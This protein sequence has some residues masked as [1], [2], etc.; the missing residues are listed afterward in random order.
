VSSFGEYATL[1]AVMVAMGIALRQ[2]RAD[3]RITKS[4]VTKTLVNVAWY[5]LFS[6]VG[7]AI[8]FALLLTAHGPHAE[9]F[10]IG[11]F[12]VWILIGIVWMTRT[13]PRLREPPAWLM[14]RWTG[15]DWV[16]I[17]AAVACVLGSVFGV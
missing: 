9:F 4:F 7:I 16:L 17:A 6:A 8:L 15:L 13:A 11:F 1:I 12:V 10:S 3:P 2:M 5:L 14:K